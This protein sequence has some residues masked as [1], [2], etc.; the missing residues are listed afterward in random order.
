MQIKELYT[1]AIKGNFEWLALL[2]EFL[3]F[4]KEVLTF[5]DDYKELDLYFKPNN[6]KRMNQILLEYKQKISGE[7]RMVI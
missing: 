5:E 7:G 3:V 1:E 4:E 6:K 2:I